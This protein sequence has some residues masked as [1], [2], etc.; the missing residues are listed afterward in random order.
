MELILWRHA[1]AKSGTPD[2]KRALNSK[3]RKQALK[4]A[5][6]LDA[7]L[8]ETCKIL[9]SPSVRTLQTAEEL[10]RKFRIHPDL[11]PDA[12]AA[13]IL[14]AANWPDA[15]EPVLIVG[16]QPALGKIAAL[17]IAGVDQ[18]WKIRRGSVWWISQRERGE[19]SENGIFLRAVISPDTIGNAISETK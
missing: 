4:M 13:T 3:G 11:G 12:D 1:E 14:A 17:L 19:S 9:V 2:D 18:E 5:N 16:H 7:N 8:P 10:G 6:W 15:K